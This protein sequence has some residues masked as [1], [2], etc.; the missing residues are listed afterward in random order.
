MLGMKGQKNGFR[1]QRHG[2]GDDPTAGFQSVVSRRED[3]F[4]QPATDENRVRRSQPVEGLRRARGD[5]TDA[6]RGEPRHAH[7][8]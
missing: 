1:F 2:M 3:A 4:R 8:P 6:G 7:A 5:D